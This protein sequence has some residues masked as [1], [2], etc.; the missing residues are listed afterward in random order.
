MKKSLIIF[1]LIFK[2]LPAQ[3]LPYGVPKYFE[4]N[5]A[6]SFYKIDL[7]VPSLFPNDIL[8][9][10]K[11]VHFKFHK[12]YFLE[13]KLDKEEAF[14]FEL[15]NSLFPEN[16]TLNFI[17]LNTKGWVGPYTQNIIVNNSPFI[18]GQMKT[19]RIL[20]EISIPKGDDPTFPIQGISAPER[21]E[22]FEQSFSRPASRTR[23][24]NNKILLCGYW[25]PTNECIRPFSRNELFK[26]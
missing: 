10:I 7:S 22:N 21:P 23:E 14:H 20:I 15:I 3:E 25:P 16:M 9:L 5:P 4:L 2:I 18:S 6:G 11:P 17:D 26:F 1:I 12:I 19:D 8:N 13:L 24:P